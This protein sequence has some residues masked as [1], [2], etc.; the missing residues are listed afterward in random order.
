LTLPGFE[1]AVEAAD[2]L[3]S[4]VRAVQFDRLAALTALKRRHPGGWILLQDTR[5]L[6]QSPEGTLFVCGHECPRLAV[7]SAGDVLSGMIGALLAQGAG[8]REAL[9]QACLRQGMAADRWHECHRA[10]SMLAE[11]IIA[12]LVN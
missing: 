9:V 3:D 6:I 12:D 5:R 11:D 8:T 1:Y 4:S 2:L 10:D 7:A